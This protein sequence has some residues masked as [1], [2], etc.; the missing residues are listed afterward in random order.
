MNAM[1]WDPLSNTF[2]DPFDGLESISRVKSV[3]S[4]IPESASRRTVVYACHPLLIHLGVGLSAE[5]RTAVEGAVVTFGKVSVERVWPSWKFFWACV[6]RL[7]YGTS[8]ANMRRCFGLG[9]TT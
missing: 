1:A 5:L 4:V 9:S 7:P 2:H 8:S 6:L 3:Q